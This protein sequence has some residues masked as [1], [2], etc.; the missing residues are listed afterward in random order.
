MALSVLLIITACH[1]PS[2]QENNLSI[3]QAGAVSEC[4]VIKYRRGEACIPLEPKRI[5]ALDVPAVLDPLLALGIK[6]VGTVVDSFGNGQDWSGKRYF[7]ALLPELVEGIEIVG[8]EATPS[9][10]KI[11]KLKP[12][13]ILMADQSE[14]AFEQLSKVAPTVLTDVFRN[15]IPIKENFRKIAEIAGK[16]KEA[17][18]ILNQYEQ[19]ISNV[20]EQ[21]S[22]RLISS[23]ISVLG[24]HQNHLSIP[25]NWA[26]HL[27]VFQDIGLKVKPALLEPDEYVGISFEVI[28]D[29][30]ADIMF[31]ID[32]N[33]SSKAF[34]QNPLIQ[35][36]DAVK[37][38]HAYIVNGSIWDFYGPIGINL[39]LDDLEEYL[40]EGGSR[41][42]KR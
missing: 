35:S 20:K 2:T 37:N 8:V 7:P 13:L 33:T 15:R 9:V 18:E 6:P 10:E 39:F 19:R 30:D 41:G 23:E 22:D 5:V 26:S 38:G 17:E 34:Y 29:F 36:L 28:S 32:F 1:K 12:D 42:V 25:G 40:V 16:K 21:L 27:Q 4:R 31:F 3:V 24:Y 11:L 14:L